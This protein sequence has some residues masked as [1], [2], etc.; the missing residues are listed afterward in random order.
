MIAL[1]CAAAF[2]PHAEELITF[3]VEEYLD[4]AGYEADPTLRLGPPS[5]SQG[6]MFSGSQ[7][8]GPGG[9]L[10]RADIALKA[11]AL[12]AMARACVPDAEGALIPA[13]ISAAAAS[14]MVLLERCARLCGKAI[15]CADRWHL[16]IRLLRDLVSMPCTQWMVCLPVH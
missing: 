6:S 8:S 11:A 12:K 13:E 2:A 16:S 4:G 15:P 9:E 10:P 5:A 1:S 14:Y 3:V 7:F